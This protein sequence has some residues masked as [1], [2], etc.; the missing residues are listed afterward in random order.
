MTSSSL[1]TYTRLSPNHSGR[2]RSEITKITPHHMAG[3]LSVHTCGEVF[4]S[5]YREASAHYGIDTE[6]NVGNYVIEENHPWT[7]SDWANDDA[8]ITIEVA[9]ESGA[10]EWKVSDAAWYKLVDL[11]VDIIQR[12]PGIKRA[13]GRPG[14][15]YT[16]D[17]YGSLT[18]HQMFAPTACPGPYMHYW[19]GALAEAVNAKLDEGDAPTAPAPPV[20]SEPEPT[21]SSGAVPDVWLRAQTTDGT[22]LPWTKYPDYAGWQP[23][24]PI[25]YLCVSCDW[26]I[27]VQAYTSNGWLDP[28][29]NP[30][31]IDD[32]VDGCAGDGSAILALKMYLESPNGDKVVE[33]RVAVASEWYLPQRDEEVSDMQDGYAGDMSNP[34]YKIEADITDL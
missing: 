15:N 25:A 24:G 9:N 33:Y 22:V 5:P 14:L 23:N 30:D 21:P 2:R 6:A 17:R 32:K 18:E 13:D 31:N 19:M 26:P 16:G 20:V 1:A 3:N 28:L 4:A 29:W 34:I 7:S 8:A 12:N 10:P 27:R 11:C